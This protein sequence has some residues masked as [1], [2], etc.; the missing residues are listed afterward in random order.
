MRL[1]CCSICCIGFVVAIG[2]GARFL[3]DTAAKAKEVMTTESSKIAGVPVSIDRVELGLG[4]ASMIGLSVA[5]P[6]GY[7]STPYFVRCDR[8]TPEANLFKLW[9]ASFDFVTIEHLSIQGL[10]VYVDEKVGLTVGSN[11]TSNAK[12]IMSYID[13][14]PIDESHPSFLTDPKRRYVIKQM[15]VKDM[16]VH[17][18]ANSL[19]VKEI[20]VPPTTVSD[21]G[22]KQNGVNVMQLFDLVTRSLTVVTL[23]GEETNEWKVASFASARSRRLLR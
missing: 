12:T 1:C 10:E 17:I 18:Y 11:T 4:Q 3:S 14:T 20:V 19:R 23:N 2:V 16:R 7:V 13:S 5:N 21:I 8:I 9:Q 22:V 6:P 15:E